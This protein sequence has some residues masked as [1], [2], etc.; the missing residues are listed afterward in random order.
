MWASEHKMT[1][2]S[3]RGATFA[4]LEKEHNQSYTTVTDEVFKTFIGNNEFAKHNWE[5]ISEAVISQYSGDYEIVGVRTEDMNYL[6]NQSGFVRL[7]ISTKNSKFLFINSR[8]F[9]KK[10]LAAGGRNAERRNAE[11]TVIS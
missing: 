5:N 7:K 11:R 4:K 9:E 10:Q 6:A 8:V 3:Y 2:L 1:L